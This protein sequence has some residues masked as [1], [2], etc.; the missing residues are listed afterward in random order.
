MHPLRRTDNR[1]RRPCGI[2][3][4]VTEANAHLALQPI[5]A[6]ARNTP[7]ITAFKPGQSPPLVK[8]LFFDGLALHAGV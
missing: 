2:P 3:S 5:C 8:T 7:R 6:A 4:A 1:D